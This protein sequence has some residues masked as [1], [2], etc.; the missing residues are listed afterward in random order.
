MKG[1]LLKEF[2]VWKKIG[3]AF[4]IAYIALGAAWSVL[5]S[6]SGVLLGMI[7]VSSGR[8]FTE[9]DKN[10]WPDYSR[11]LPY[12]TVHLVSARYIL[13]WRKHLLR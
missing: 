12:S 4:L 9:D 2:Y 1:A 10:S 11:A 7:V 8:S 5:G 13:F 3:L 6:V